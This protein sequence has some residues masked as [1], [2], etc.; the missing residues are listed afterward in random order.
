M[1]ARPTGIRKGLTAAFTAIVLFLLCLIPALLIPTAHADGGGSGIGGGNSGSGTPETGEG[2]SGG[3]DDEPEYADVYYFSDYSGSVTFAQ[4]LIDNGITG[5]IKLFNYSHDVFQATVRNKYE[6]GKYDYIECA[7]VIFEMRYGF[8]NETVSDYNFALFLK[9]FFET[10][11]F[12]ECRIMFVCGTDEQLFESNAD[13]TEF[14]DYVDIHVN[15]DKMSLFLSTIF[16]NAADNCADKM[17]RDCTIILDKHFAPIEDIEDIDPINVWQGWFFQYRLIPYINSTWNTYVNDFTDENECNNYRDFLNDVNININILCHIG[18]NEFYDFTDNNI[19]N[20]DDFS[21]FYYNYLKDNY[22]FAIGGTWDD[23]QYADEWI[24]L[25]DT[26]RSYSGFIKFSSDKLPVDYFPIYVYNTDGYR[27]SIYSA[28]YVHECNRAYKDI[29]YEIMIDFIL[30]NYLYV[31]NNWNGRCIVTHKTIT[32]SQNGWISLSV[33]YD[34]NECFCMC[35]L[36]YN[37]D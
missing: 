14:L 3:G 16:F 20:T 17:L 7:P 26:L 9:D 32:I 33:L 4:D 31:Y 34:G 15:T 13:Y 11:K 18:G 37:E 30:N 6:A 2:G 29:I 36:C 35:W 21:A 23:H 10:L 8:D 28:N 19:V 25:I 1:T 22:I 27:N 12:R 24:D 5:S